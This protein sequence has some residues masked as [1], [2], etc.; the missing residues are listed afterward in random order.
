MV[1]CH[2]LLTRVVNREMIDLVKK[3]LIIL[4]AVLFLL[5]FVFALSTKLTARN[6]QIKITEA[7]E[8]KASLEYGALYENICSILTGS[9]VCELGSSDKD[10]LLRFRE[11][12][13][14]KC[15]ANPSFP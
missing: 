7:C 11:E 4:S 15:L 14:S 13:L 6:N 9:P 10:R 12:R 8:L 1:A 5:G 3:C 2:C